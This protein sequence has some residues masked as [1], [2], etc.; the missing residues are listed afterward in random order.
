[1][2]ASAATQCT[3]LV[4]AAGPSGTA[5]ELGAIRTALAGRNVPAICAGF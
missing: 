2:M 5:P 4:N 3:A 1:M